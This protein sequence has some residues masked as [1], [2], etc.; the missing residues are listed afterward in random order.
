MNDL[1][2]AWWVTVQSW[3]AAARHTATSEHDERGEGVISAA[4]AVMIVAFLG[5]GMWLAFRGIFDNTTQTTDEQ[6][7]QIGN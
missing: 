6:I 1:T 3:L 2:T 5:A 4:I 7:R